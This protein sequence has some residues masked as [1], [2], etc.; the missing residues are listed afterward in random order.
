MAREV[1]DVWMPVVDGISFDEWKKEMDIRA[2]RV[3]IEEPQEGA[4]VRYFVGLDFGKLQDYSAV[5]IV[6]QRLAPSGTAHYF[7]KHIRRFPLI[8]RY[9]E[10]AKALKKMDQQLQGYAAAKGKEAVITWICDCTGVG[11]GVADILE[12]VMPESD[13]VKCYITG[14]I[15]PTIDFEMREV[16]LPKSQLISTLVALFDSKR[17]NLTKRSKEI[18]DMLDELANFEIHVSEETGRDSYGAKSGT[19]DDL[20][21]SLALACW[22][23]ELAAEEGAFEPLRMW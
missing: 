12:K 8:L 15:S 22:A 2:G 1:S 10:V 14:G 5:S 16:R 19:H 6:E 11:E 21:V 17:I 23:A 3:N 9:I 7:V 13:I 18:D 20:L 4:A